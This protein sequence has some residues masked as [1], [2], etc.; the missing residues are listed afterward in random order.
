MNKQ[1]AFWMVWSPTGRQP[2]VKHES[3]ASAVCEAE[4]LARVVSGAEF[5]V[6]RAVALR[7]VDAMQRV[8]LVTG[9]LASEHDEVPF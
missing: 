2:V 3:E 6:L 5:F 1:K 4:R 8:E 7:T 9:L